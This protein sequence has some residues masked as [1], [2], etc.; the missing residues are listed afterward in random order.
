M[1]FKIK[2]DEK[3]L[4]KFSLIHAYTGNGAFLPGLA[5][6]MGLIMIIRGIGFGQGLQYA[7]VGA[8]FIALFVVVNPVMLYTKAKKQAL[9]NPMYQVDSEYELNE[10]GIQVR[11]Q[12]QEGKL[13]WNQIQRVQST[14]G[15]YI[16]YTGQ[17]SAFIFPENKL[18]DQCESVMNYIYNHV[19]NYVKLPKGAVRK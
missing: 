2:L 7:G 8:V 15:M 11:I 13:A 16:I 3:D 9:T 10:E 14:F 5:M 18:G 12:D 19:G 6:V 1:N 4:F 17:K